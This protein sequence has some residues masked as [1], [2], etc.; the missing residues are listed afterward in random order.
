LAALNLIAGQKA[1]SAI[2][3]EASARYLNLGLE[4]LADDCW[5][6]EYELTL[7]LYESAIDIE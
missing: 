5:Q 1:K 3:N 6:T 7:S 4:L 2:A